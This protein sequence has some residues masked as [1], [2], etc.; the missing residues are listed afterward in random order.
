M[1]FGL[2]QQLTREGPDPNSSAS[3]GSSVF[4]SF[5][6]GMPRSVLAVTWGYPGLPSIHYPINSRR[7]SARI[8]V[9]PTRRR[10]A[11]APAVPQP[12][13]LKLPSDP[14]DPAAVATEAPVSPRPWSEGVPE[15]SREPPS[16]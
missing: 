7:K 16:M 1:C 2:D 10:F 4:P 6:R 8:H 3:N 13:T 15:A 14:V 11:S 5:V 12:P 9:H